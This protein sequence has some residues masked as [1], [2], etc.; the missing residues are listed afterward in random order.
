MQNHK[1]YSASLVC[2]YEVAES[3]SITTLTN[4]VSYGTYV[5]LE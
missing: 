5:L 2:E 4:M 1:A 3:K